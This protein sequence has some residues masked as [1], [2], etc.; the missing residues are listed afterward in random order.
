MF[1]LLI[2]VYFSNYSVILKYNT[3]TTS[4]MY[5]IPNPNARNLI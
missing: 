1:N 3:Y 4:Y 5:L 2:F